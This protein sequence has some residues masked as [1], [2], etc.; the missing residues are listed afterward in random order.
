MLRCLSN[1]RVGYENKV[2][3]C[4]FVRTLASTHRLCTFIRT[5]NPSISVIGPNIFTHSFLSGVILCGGI[6]IRLISD[7]RLLLPTLAF[8]G[9]NAGAE[10]TWGSVVDVG[11]ESIMSSSSG[12]V[13]I[14]SVTGFNASC[15]SGTE[16][17]EPSSTSSM[18]SSPPAGFGI[19]ESG[20]VAEDFLCSFLRFFLRGAT[21]ALVGSGC[22]VWVTTIVIYV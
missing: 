12:S 11:L 19:V 10:D 14:S 17:E 7:L 22:V 6:G 5:C 20:V 8:T 13:A 3:F 2:K 21:D 1:E 9:G 4:E 18:S 16:F 15:C